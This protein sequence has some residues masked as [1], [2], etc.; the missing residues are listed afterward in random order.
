MQDS[1][2]SD[3]A[4][5]SR[6]RFDEQMEKYAFQNAL[7]QVFQVIGRANKYIDENE[8]WRLAKDEARKPRL[9]RVLYNLLETIRIS[10]GLASPL[11]AVETGRCDRGDAWA[12]LRRTGR[13]WGT[14]GVPP[15]GCGGADSARR[16][17]PRID[18]AQELQA[19]RLFA[20]SGPGS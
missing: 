12:A 10:A 6:G 11:C 1:G 20:Q 7:A 18:A 17:F 4:A 5:G 3:A 16:S 8:P 14:R 13:A 9:A 2:F 15:P 19:R